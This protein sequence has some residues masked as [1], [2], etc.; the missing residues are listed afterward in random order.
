MSVRGEAKS[1]E[2]GMTIDEIRK[3]VAKVAALA[4]KGDH[5]AAFSEE[6]TLH[7]DVLRAIATNDHAEFPAILAR[8]ALKTNDLDFARDC[9]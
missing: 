2:R 3:R 5:E 9:A 4:K 7:D 1:L 8:E 6:T